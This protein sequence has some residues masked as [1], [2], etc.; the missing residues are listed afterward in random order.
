MSVK[1][2]ADAIASAANDLVQEAEK[3]E[4]GN[5]AAGRRAR[6]ASVQIGKHCVQFRKVSLDS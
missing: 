3:Q 1:T 5:Q 4:S 6:R 2:I